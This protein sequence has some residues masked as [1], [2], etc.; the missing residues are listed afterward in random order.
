MEKDTW[1]DISSEMYREYVYP[2]GY[3][4]RIDNPLKVKISQSS[5]GGHA[6]RVTTAT[7]GYYVASGWV[8]IRW[9]ARDGR[10]LFVG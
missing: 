5:L 1:V 3:V 2:S 9:E 10:A 8:A 7:T 6:H 4:L